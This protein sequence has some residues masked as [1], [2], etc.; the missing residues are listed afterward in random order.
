MDLS[1]D[2]LKNEFLKENEISFSD[3]NDM[4]EQI[5][6]EDKCFYNLLSGEYISLFNEVGSIAIDR[7]DI[8]DALKAAKL[9][10]DTDDMA[11]YWL[12]TPFCR[13]TEIIDSKK[14]YSDRNVVH[15]DEIYPEDYIKGVFEK[16]GW[17]NAADVLKFEGYAKEFFKGVDKNN[18]NIYPSFYPAV[19]TELSLL[20]A[21]ANDILKYHFSDEIKEYV[22]G[23]FS[24]ESASDWLDS[25]YIGE[26]HEAVM[27]NKDSVY[28]T[29]YDDGCIEY[30]LSPSSTTES[31]T[32]MI[33]S[34]E[35]FEKAVL[36]VSEEKFIHDYSLS[37]AQYNDYINDMNNA[38]CV[39][40]SYEHKNDIVK[41]LSA[42]TQIG[43]R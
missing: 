26:G 42:K 41:K 20:E 22:K 4:H 10:A 36:A 30:N 37:G 15:N 2:N 18:N 43:N 16:K 38:G 33:F 29:V 25:E 8:D 3:S 17:I 23:Y 9:S 39:Y 32:P 34:K 31:L 5:V 19:M 21:A 28:L 6:N 27:L 12:A 24:V 11:D 40:I 1:D 13:H 7:L 35:E 14:Y